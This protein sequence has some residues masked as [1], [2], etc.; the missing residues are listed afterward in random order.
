MNLDDAL[1]LLGGDQPERLLQ[2]GVDLQVLEDDRPRDEVLFVHQLLQEYFAARKVAAA[3]S[4]FSKLAA[5]AR[6][7]WRADETEQPLAVIPTPICARASALPVRSGN[8]ATRVS[9]DTKARAV[10]TSCRQ[11]LTSR[12][13]LIESAATT[14]M[15]RSPCTRSRSRHS[16]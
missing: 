13:A 11:S 10:I 8:W 15:M 2:G 4:D 7:P 3:A 6:S 9:S 14:A 12:A 5:N 1:A 16:Q